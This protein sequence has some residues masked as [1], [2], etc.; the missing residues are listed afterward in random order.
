MT[1]VIDYAADL[2]AIASL[3]TQPQR[4]DRTLGSALHSLG[5]VIAFDLAVLYRLEG[6][7]LVPAAADGPLDSTAIRRHRLSLRDH[8]RL[9]RVLDHGR[10]MSLTEEHH[11]SEEGDPYDGVLDLP[12]GHACMVI[13][14]R[15]ADAPVGLITLDRRVCEPYS[16]AEVSLADVYAQLASTALVF[17]D[18]AELLDRYR[19]RLEEQNS[20]LGA[21]SSGDAESG[22]LLE[23]TRSPKM[24]RFVEFARQVAP[25]PLPVLIR[26]ETGSGKEVAARA[27]HEWSDRARRPFVSVNCA[28]IPD[29][30]VESELF[31]HRKGAFSGAVRDRAGRF[32]AANGGT[33]FLDEIGDMPPV[34]QA[35]LLRALQEGSFEPVGSDATV[36]VDVR[37]IAASHVDLE[38]A[39]RER[40]F[41]E[42]LFYRLAAVPLSLPPLR[43][44]SEDIVEIA[45]SR[46]RQLAAAPGR[47]PWRLGEGAIEE[48]CARPWPGNV[49]ELLHTIERATIVVPAGTIERDHLL[50]DPLEGPVAASEHEAGPTGAVPPFAEAEKQLLRRALDA[51][52]GKIYGADGAAA[53]LRLK[54]TTLQAK[55]KKH[56][57]R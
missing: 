24:R 56:R 47:G 39:I 46:L 2:K 55:L 51:T 26:G 48:L 52:G 45:H 12:H 50:L 38:A 44:R 1:G 6:D 54:P 28:A 42:D 3:T 30:L 25:T 8:P 17:A 15:S 41:R 20:S 22:E 5:Q 21:T 33:L 29:N 13:P 16:P 10:P 36:R 31:G 53:L 23:R 43:E 35:K 27:L 37:V 14:L 19:R 49:R 34:A 9:A 18:Q 11:A 7:T 57:L 32:V 40:R 4:L